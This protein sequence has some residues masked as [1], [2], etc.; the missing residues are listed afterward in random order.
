MED[1]EATVK[2][3]TSAETNGEGTR[4]AVATVIETMLRHADAAL[5]QAKASGKNCC[6]VYSET[7]LDKNK[8]GTGTSGCS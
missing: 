5:Y 7:E 3:L 2:E 4:L 6:V 8:A 1:L